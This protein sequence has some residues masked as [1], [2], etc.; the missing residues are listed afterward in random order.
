MPDP[1]SVFLSYARGD[2]KAVEKLYR[3]LVAEGFRPWMDTQNLLPGEN[4]RTSIQGAIRDS[5]VFVACLSN[6][7]VDTRGYFQREIRQALDSWL[8]RLEEDIYL[9]PARLEAC[10]IPDQL[11]E[12]CIG[13]ISRFY[14]FQVLSDHVFNIFKISFALP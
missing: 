13:Q 11:R 5:D 14:E 10:A 4:W 1:I 9:I 12:F 6:K 8:E 7:T 2:E 3:R